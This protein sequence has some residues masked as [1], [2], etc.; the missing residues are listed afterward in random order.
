M[1]LGQQYSPTPEL[2][3]TVTKV[4]APPVKEEKVE[5]VKVVEAKAPSTKKAGW[6]GF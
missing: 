1:C 5:I 6:F 4:Q 3:E 2:V